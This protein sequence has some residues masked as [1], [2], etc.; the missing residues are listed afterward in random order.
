M[1]KFLHT[2]TLEGHL[3]RITYYNPENHYTIAKV[4]TIKTDNLVTIV[5]SLVAVSLGQALKMK[6]DWEIHPKYLF[7]LFFGWLS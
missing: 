1:K 4:K 2:T 3:E 6:G 7:Y 5:G